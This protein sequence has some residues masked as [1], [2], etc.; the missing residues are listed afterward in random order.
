VD[1]ARANEAFLAERAWQGAWIAQRFGLR[2]A[3]TVT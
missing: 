2:E 1:P 3:A